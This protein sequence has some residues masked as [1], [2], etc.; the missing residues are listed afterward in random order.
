MVESMNKRIFINFFS[1]FCLSFSTRFYEEAIANLS[2]LYIISNPSSKLSLN[3]TFR[4]AFR[5][6]LTGK[7][8]VLVLESTKQLIIIFAAENIEVLAFQQK[9]MISGQPQQTY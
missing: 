1:L 6:A 4:T 2:K 3:S 8:V 5:M 7:Y 9:R